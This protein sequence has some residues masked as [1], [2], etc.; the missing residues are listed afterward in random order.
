MPRFDKEPVIV[1]IDPTAPGVSLPAIRAAETPIA[2]PSQEQVEH[3]LVD[4]TN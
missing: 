4:G 2:P 1:F 3:T